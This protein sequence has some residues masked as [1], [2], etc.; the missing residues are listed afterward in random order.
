MVIVLAQYNGKGDFKGMM[1]IQSEDVP[2]G[3]TIKL[4]VPVDNTI[5]DIARLKAFCLES[6]ASLIPMGNAVNF[7]AK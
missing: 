5:G 4:S 7:P 1:Y 2:M 6:F 3:S